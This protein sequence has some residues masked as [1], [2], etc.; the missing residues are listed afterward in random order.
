MRNISKQMGWGLGLLLFGFGV[1][2][3]E[4][5]TLHWA[6]RTALAT[7]AS[8]E[9]AEVN[10]PAGTRVKKGDALITLQQSV[11][12]TRVN[13][14]E[15]IVKNTR[16]QRTEAKAELDR[17]QEMYDQTML[18][19]HDLQLTK[20]AY[21]KADAE[22]QQARADLA[23]AQFMLQQSILR[24]PFDAIVLNVAVT[25]GEVVNNQQQSREL[26]V[27]A[28]SDKML[29]R[30][31][32]DLDDA[33]SLKPG[34]SISVKAGGKSIQGTISNIDLTGGAAGSN[35]GGKATVD[36]I[37][38]IAVNSDVAPGSKVDIDL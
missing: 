11:F 36:V 9:V 6:N 10:A 18:A 32:I 19:L 30:A 24:A 33:L 21:I 27:I 13:A 14:L 17:N 29:A 16:E 20:L 1:A 37:F 3:A 12:T 35:G 4:E 28:S 22:Y 38:P 7:L 15:A 31:V 2:H 23:H 25:A 8:G 5:A 26:M 34:Q